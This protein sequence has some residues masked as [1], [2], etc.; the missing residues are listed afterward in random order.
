MTLASRRRAT[1][2]TPQ[3]QW[4][5]AWVVA[6]VVA[7]GQGLAATGDLRVP[8]RAQRS[9]LPFAYGLT[10]SEGLSEF[11]EFRWAS[12]RAV[13]VQ[14]TAGPWLQ[15]TIWAPHSDVATRPVRYAV[16]LNGRDVITREARDRD[17]QTYYLQMPR[18]ERFVMIEFHASRDAQPDR[19]L[20][21]ATTWLG[22]VPA[23]APP[24]RVIPY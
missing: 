23:G 24:D 16:S 9:Q 15:L 3:W 4:A 22:G 20:Q 18:D 11:G 13:S 1:A 10:P 2:S 14:P 8:R 17:P 21:I 12:A 19:A 5:L 6:I 7:I